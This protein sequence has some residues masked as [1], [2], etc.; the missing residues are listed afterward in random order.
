[1][2][3]LRY[4]S[5]ERQLRLFDP[6]LR[7]PGSMRNVAGSYVERLTGLLTGARRLVTDARFEICPDLK[8]SDDLFFESKSVGKTNKVILYKHRIEK[9]VGF[10]HQIVYWIWNHAGNVGVAETVGEIEHQISS[11]LKGIYA[12]DLQSVHRHVNRPT[13]KV[14]NYYYSNHR[15]DSFK[16]DGW[17][18]GLREFDAQHKMDVIVNG[19]HVPIYSTLDSIDSMIARRFVL[20]R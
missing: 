16:G 18:V 2:S 4:R 14:N 6:P 20:A 19:R 12:V 10:P 9:E 7:S 13:S 15:A 1:M 3:D 17:C 8:F 5:E 11:T